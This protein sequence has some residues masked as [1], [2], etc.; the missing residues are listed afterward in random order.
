MKLNV[1]GT[2][3]I[4][5]PEMEWLNANRRQLEK[6]YPGQWV[7]ISG[8]QIVGFGTMAEAGRMASE[9]GIERPLFTA[10]P[11]LDDQEKVF[12]GANRRA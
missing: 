4:R 1:L 2:K 5:A 12:I 10:F 8:S 6:Q 9:R 7:A 3:L 11:R